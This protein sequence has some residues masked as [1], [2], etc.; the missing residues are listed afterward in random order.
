M[1]YDITLYFTYIKAN[2]VT[3][4]GVAVSGK[5]SLKIECIGHF[6]LMEPQ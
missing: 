3:T 1:R 2:F 5:A 4:F 6:V